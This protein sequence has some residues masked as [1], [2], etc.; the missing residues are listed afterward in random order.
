MDRAGQEMGMGGQEGGHHLG[1]FTDS[2][3]S[4]A[5]LIQLLCGIQESGYLAFSM[6]LL[7][8]PSEIPGSK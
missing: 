8:Y 5:S 2:A 4:R 7:S 3:Q 1:V 6:K